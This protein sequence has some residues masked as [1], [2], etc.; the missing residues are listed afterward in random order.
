MWK[1]ATA[2]RPT[3]SNRTIS[4]Y[5]SAER[6][7]VQSLPACGRRHAV[8]RTAMWVNRYPTSTQPVNLWKIQ[9]HIPAENSFHRPKSSMRPRL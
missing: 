5:S 4:S 1:T 8:E 6:V 9:A 2:S 7:G 3:S